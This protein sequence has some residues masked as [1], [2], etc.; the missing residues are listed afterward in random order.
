ISWA[1]M[2]RTLQWDP[3]YAKAYL[4]Q[5][6]LTTPL[7]GLRLPD[8]VPCPHLWKSYLPSDLA[9]GLHTIEVRA[10]DPYE[11]AFTEKRALNVLP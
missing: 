11:R 5:D 9:V 3:E 4:A 2:R 7:P 8:P 6:D 1:S 10:T